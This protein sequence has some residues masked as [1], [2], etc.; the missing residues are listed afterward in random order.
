MS[1]HQIEPLEPRIALSPVIT[2]L[3]AQ[4]TE[5]NPG[6]SG[7]TEMVFHVK[8][9]EASTSEVKV[10]FATADGTAHK[11]TEYVEQHGTLTFAD[12]VVDQTVTVALNK[13]AIN[14]TA[15]HGDKTLLLNLTNPVGTGVTIGKAQAT[16][17]IVDDEAPLVSV[18]DV[19]VVEQDPGAL[20]PT[21]LVF[22]VHLSKACT[23]EVTLN[24]ATADGAGSSGAHAGTDY[25]E[26]HGTLTFAP[27]ETDKTVEVQVTNNNAYS[28]DRT[29]SLN[30]SN[31]APSG[32]KL[33]ATSATGKIVE[34]DLTVSV[35]N[36]SVVEKDPGAATPAKLVFTV[37]LDHA[38]SQPITLNYATAD[39][40]G[41]NG[42]VVG[43]DY[44][45][46]HGILTFAVGETQKTIE[47]E[48]ISDNV[49]AGDRTMS[50]S[51]SSPN[52]ATM[53]MPGT[54]ATGT[55][56]E[57][58]KPVLA[59][60]A[61]SV[62]EQD[63][64]ATTKLIFT[65]DMDQASKTPVTVNFQTADGSG[66]GAAIAGLNYVATSGTLTFA[67]G[68]THKTVEVTVIDDTTY[69]P[70]RNML[71]KLSGQTPTSVAS[72]GTAQAVGTILDDETTVFASVLPQ[73]SVTEGDPGTTTNLLFTIN[74]SAAPR[75]T[76]SFHYTLVEGTAHAGVD[77]IIPSGDNTV[78]F[79]AGQT[80]K[81]IAVQVIND[82]TYNHD[83]TLSL[84]LSDPTG[85]NTAIG[86]ATGVGT[87]KD[88]ET[89]SSV[90]SVSNAQAFESA[91]KVIF[92]VTASEVWTDG[93][94]TVQYNTVDGTAVAGTD[95]TAQT[96]TLTFAA[97][98]QS[99]HTIEVLVADNATLN[100][101]RTFGLHFS[102]PSANVTAPSSATGTIL[103]NE[104]VVTIDDLGPVAEGDPT[105]GNTTGTKDFT[106][107]VR[108]SNASDSPITVDYTTADGSGAGS[109]AIAGTHYEANTGQITFAAGETDKTVVVKVFNDNTA[110]PDRD[111]NLNLTGVSGPGVLSSDAAKITS[112]ATIADD[113]IG[114]RMSVA[115]T[116]NEQTGTI[117]YSVVTLTLDRTSLLPV[118]AFL[119]SIPG[120]ATADDLAIQSG[121]VLINPGE[122]SSTVS[123]AIKPDSIPELLETFNV[124]VAA[125]TGGTAM[126]AELLGS[127]DA[128][129]TI[130][131]DDLT[132]KISDW[133]W[134][135][136]T[137]GTT[138]AT[139]T[140]Q[141][142]TAY[143]TDLT[144]HWATGN[145]TATAGSDYDSA[146]GDLVIAAGSKTGTVTVNVHGDTETSAEKFFVNIANETLNIT[147]A[148]G[149]GTILG[150]GAITG[151]PYIVS[152]T[153][154]DG[155][156]VTVYSS[157][158]VFTSTE[159]I[160]SL[161]TFDGSNLTSINL[162]S[163]FYP[164]TL[165]VS[166]AG[167]GDGH[168]NVGKITGNAFSAV[169]VDGD[170]G[171]INASSVGWL[172]VGSY[173]VESGHDGTTGTIG[174]LTGGILCEGDFAGN[175]TAGKLFD[176]ASQYVWIQGNIVGGA[177]ANTGYLSVMSPGLV[178]VGH[179]D[180]SGHVVGGNVSGGAGANSGYLS[181]ASTSALIVYGEIGGSNSAGTNSGHVFGGAV[182]LLAT[183]D[184]HGG[185]GSGS[186]LLG[187]G[188]VIN[189]HIGNVTGGGGSGSGQV[190][191]SSASTLVV[192]DLAGG[193]GEGS[194]LLRL[195][196]GVAEIVGKV[197]GGTGNS[198]G[199][200]LVGS[201][202]AAI[203]GDIQGG[204]GN[205]TGVVEFTTISSLR[206]GSGTGA[207]ITGGSG[208]SSGLVS[209]ISG[210]V[211]RVDVM[212]SIVGGHSSSSS[213]SN[214]LSGAVVSSANIGYLRVAGD[215]L[216]GTMIRSGMLDLNRAVGI[217]DV[218]GSL[219]GHAREAVGD[220]GGTQVG[221]KSLSAVIG[222]VTASY[223][224]GSV[225]SSEGSIQYLLIGGNIIGGENA[226]STDG[227]ESK[228][229]V[230]LTGAVFS[231]HLGAIAVGGDIRSGGTN[232][233]T[234]AQS[235][236]V[237]SHF[238]LGSLAVGGNLIGSADV[239]VVVS[240][241]GNRYSIGS[242]IDLAIGSVV[243]KGAIRDTEILAGYDFLAETSVRGGYSNADASIGSVTA[244]ELTRSSIVA[245]VSPGYSD[246]F[247]DGDDTV[248]SVFGVRNYA[249]IS[250]MIG[251]VIVTGSANGSD[252]A[253]DLEHSALADQTFA[254]TAQHVLSVSV[255]GQPVALQAG[256]RN[257][258]LPDHAPHLGTT[259]VRTLVLADGFDF[260]VVE[261]A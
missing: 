145:G 10:D 11:G 38:S 22:T 128:T 241:S 227:S 183:G 134:V 88:D 27:G 36:V 253:Y 65:V 158:P 218:T 216:G 245:G 194:G 49:Y 133:S 82:I 31:A 28:G 57:D 163:Q 173:G 33:P 126:N 259:P 142:S 232:G 146:F 54:P 191:I 53:T 64:G 258:V 154:N 13:D 40:T 175:L 77:Y 203:V 167:T 201:T 20:T 204:A 35:A 250:S 229:L 91:G 116:V 199:L 235:G 37:V 94:I 21:K 236:A 52:P 155:D 86:N 83:R 97:G 123:I 4:V 15:I 44:V 181:V 164:I 248:P 43:L 176:G 143:T 222:N 160:N 113:D 23:E 107:H 9:S 45:E 255:G 208:S 221:A 240:A 95:Y 260:H 198:S 132:A 230:H 247:G 62:L 256:A 237:V 200:V 170:L 100:G 211:S 79:A 197:T 161:L 73:Q 24:F 3:S 246:F 231:A 84:T 179:V 67:P 149:V 243:V 207:A 25:T 162:N 166:A 217:V 50:L 214:E 6:D 104:A 152:Y 93:P 249:G 209:L 228:G 76:A 7:P 118:T 121:N 117:S 177:A 105:Q 251:S 99:P 68:E 136:G 210:S 122:L 109:H 63:P 2:V 239:N 29:L 150:A 234:L 124:H 111:F 244:G 59:V 131:D 81:T 14:D 32:V 223:V 190:N 219:I 165:F 41:A 110:N 186:G 171:N 56:V 148:Q 180:S 188:Q 215:I 30:L 34:D 18:A 225:S 140:V 17:T 159:V 55:I 98:D 213:S 156:V 206:V 185:A 226:A 196:S 75:D 127:T 212:G 26:K 242:A 169:Y 261:V 147:K 5:K 103:D 202:L 254:I 46:N 144:F 90:L 8:L 141:L 42:A 61:T 224:G 187:V 48:V 87:I 195:T 85:M 233:A 125:P 80:Q 182:G 92:M 151:N 137:S 252:A 69:N 74:L 153:E 71:L 138:T 193:A 189:A 39:G 238:E 135:G 114:L 192:G 19:S 58:D 12:G 168:V 220:S 16:G 257:D 66:A 139:F 129:V 178:L 51:L 78:T 96:G 174:S 1:R 184:V 205:V 89:G 70:D 60:H 72:I 106:F 115:P 120:T 172:M 102:N 108:L 130:L 157:L 47:V 112:H 119:S 101:S